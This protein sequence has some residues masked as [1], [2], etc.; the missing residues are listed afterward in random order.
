MSPKGTATSHGDRDPPARALLAGVAR[1]FALYH[2]EDSDAGTIVR[3]GSTSIRRFIGGEALSLWQLDEVEDPRQFTD[4]PCLVF[5]DDY[6]D[7]EDEENLLGLHRP[8]PDAVAKA[9]WN[10]YLGNCDGGVITC[11]SP[12]NLYDL[13][14]QH[15]TVLQD[16]PR[17]RHRLPLGALSEVDRDNEYCGRCRVCSCGE[18][19]C[20]SEFTWKR[21]GLVLLHFLV[22]GCE[23]V[24]AFMLPVLRPRPDPVYPMD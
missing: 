2:A 9:I 3:L 16:G 1:G 13:L 12:A 8:S 23:L 17:A 21:N 7:A 4:G 11:E 15:G 19:L 22:G 20:G 6:L 10:M 5:S 14:V 18:P 24:A